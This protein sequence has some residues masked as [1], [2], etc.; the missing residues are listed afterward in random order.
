M[1]SLRRALLSAAAVTLS[2][3][4]VSHFQLSPVASCAPPANAAVPA[5]ASAPAPTP[6]APSF[7]HHFSLRSQFAA[8]KKVFAAW[9]LSPGARVAETMGRGA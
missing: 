2:G 9:V 1:F 6:A 8:G 7:A 4:T 3:V 5:S